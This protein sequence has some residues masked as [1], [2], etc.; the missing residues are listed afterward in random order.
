MHDTGKYVI[1]RELLMYA[2]SGY[3]I[4]MASNQFCCSSA[5]FNTVCCHSLFISIQFCQD[6]ENKIFGHSTL[7]KLWF[8][9]LG[10]IQM[11]GQLD[12]VHWYWQFKNRK[13]VHV[14]LEW[15]IEQAV[16]KTWIRQQHMLFPILQR[17]NKICCSTLSES[18]GVHCTPP[19]FMVWPPKYDEVHCTMLEFA[20]FGQTYKARVY[21]WDLRR[22]RFSWC[23]G[24]KFGAFILDSSLLLQWLMG[25]EFV[26]TYRA[27]DYDF[28]QLVHGRSWVQCYTNTDIA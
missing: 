26:Y 11:A 15:V 12:W 6:L 4:Q 13:W 5:L 10:Q 20:K 22:F 18:T 25:T 1:W 14:Q 17:S 27:T 8:W 28:S 3:P 7:S 2:G 9:T 24:P 19:E 23:V 21:Y 16:A